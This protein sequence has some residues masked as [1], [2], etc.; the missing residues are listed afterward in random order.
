[1]RNTVM[2]VCVREYEAHLRRK[3]EFTRLVTGAHDQLSALFD[4]AGTSAKSPRDAA[5]LP[6][7]ELVGLR[8]RKHAILD[9]LRRDYE[10]LRATWGGR[11]DYQ[12]WF[13]RSLNNARLNDVDTYYRLVPA[14]HRLLQ[15]KGGDL[16][17]FYR[18]ASVLGKL[19]KAERHRRLQR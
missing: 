9:Q 14:F 18:E 8:V 7:E 3:A 6:G 13:H 1:M 10:N 12:R 5:S 4:E 17:A 2:L 19:E 15:E 16:E 11:T